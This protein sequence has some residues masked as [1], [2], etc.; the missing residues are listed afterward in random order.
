M[1]AWEM[2]NRIVPIHRSGGRLIEEQDQPEADEAACKVDGKDRHGPG[3]HR[4]PD[5]QQTTQSE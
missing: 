3:A 4:N 1:D 2:P 5:P